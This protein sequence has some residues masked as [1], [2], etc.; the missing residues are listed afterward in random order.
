MGE[1]IQFK[2]DFKI[3]GLRNREAGIALAEMEMM[4]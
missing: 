4:E 1:R 2:A 3:F